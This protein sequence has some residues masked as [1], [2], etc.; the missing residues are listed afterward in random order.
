[1]PV[2]SPAIAVI[3][4]PWLERRYAPQ[5]PVLVTST[6][7][8]MPADAEAPPD[9]VTPFT[10]RPAASAAR[11][12]RSSSSTD[13]ASGSSRSSSGKFLRQ[14]RGIGKARVLVL[15]RDP[16]H[17]DRALGERVHIGDDIVGRHHRLLVPDQHAQADVVA[18]GALGL[19]DIAVADFDA[20]RHAAHGD[21]VGR[22]RTG[23]LGRLD[24]TLREIGQRRLIEQALRFFGRTFGCSENGLRHCLVLKL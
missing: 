11:A 2:P 3:E 13:G 18:L 16:R 23:A 15:R 20:L 5:K 17:G 19:L 8:P 14:Q 10:A 6:M 1:M 24:Q 9:L 7:P 12:R 22:I 4:M 21:C